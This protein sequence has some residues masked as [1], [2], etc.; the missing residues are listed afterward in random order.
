MDDDDKKTMT[1]RER[2]REQHRQEILA[3]AEAIFTGIILPTSCIF[4]AKVT[5]IFRLPLPDTMVFAR[6]DNPSTSTSSVW[7]PSLRLGGGG[8]L[9]P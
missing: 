5:V 1:R 9:C 8:P 3:A 2:E 7:L 6:L 4:P